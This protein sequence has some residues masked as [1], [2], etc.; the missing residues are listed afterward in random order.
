MIGVGTRS[1]IVLVIRPA[2]T[3]AVVL[4]RLTV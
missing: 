3:A 1:R 2:L 4:V